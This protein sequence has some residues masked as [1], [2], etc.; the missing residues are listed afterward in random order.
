MLRLSFCSLMLLVL[1]CAPYET[2]GSS[3]YFGFSIGVS[4][5]PPPPRVVF[6]ERPSLVLVPGTSVYVIENSGYDVFRY[7]SHLYLSSG[8]YWYR[9]RGYGQPFRVCDVR[10]VPRAVLTVPGDRWK[11]R[12][13][14]A[15]DDHRGRHRGRGRDRDRDD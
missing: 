11:H 5:A 6:V 8:G 9:S 12:S 4:S 2:V 13:A 15:R 3:T 7:G 10:S 1:S 14:Y